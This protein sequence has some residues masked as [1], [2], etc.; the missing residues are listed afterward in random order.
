MSKQPYK[1][2]LGLKPPEN[3]ERYFV[4]AIGA[5]VAD[6]LIRQA[7]LKPGERVLDVACGTG[8]VTRLV[9][10]QV[11]SD[12]T[13]MGLDLNPGMLAVARTETPSEMSIEWRE[14]NAED[15]PLPDEAF[16][17]VLCQM[18]LQFMED[19]PRALQEMWRVLAPGGR[20]I[21]NV[22][23]PAQKI[24]IDFAETLKQYIS[25]EAAGFVTQV[26]SL[27]DTDEI[28]QLMGKAGFSEITIE[29]NMKTLRLP[30]PKE[31]M[32]QYIQ[33][34]PLAGIVLNADENARTALEREVVQKWQRFCDG[35]SM[36]YQQRI[37]TAVARK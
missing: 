13:V 10:E 7:A 11:G 5:P 27:H 16:D 23:G 9:S 36:A 33:S 19:K 3:Y 24:F 12:G 26:F 15:M 6:D 4:P 21:L 22:P 20:L 35:D 31:F 18:G 2:A 8:V 34:T 29:A 32:W 17:V 37:V 25:P 1:R 14:A 30:L 28:Q